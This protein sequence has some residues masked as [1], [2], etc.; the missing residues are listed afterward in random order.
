MPLETMQSLHQRFLKKK[1]KE[2]KLELIL[3]KY[4]AWS[5]NR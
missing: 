2:K 1:K 4:L 5:V 3:V